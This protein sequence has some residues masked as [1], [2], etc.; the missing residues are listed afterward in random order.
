VLYVADYQLRMGIVIANA[1]DF[2]E[3]GFIENAMPEGVTVDPTG[4]VYAG[5]VLPRNL[6][7]FVRD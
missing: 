6:K 7:K 2:T 3:I 5:E 1:S 4:I